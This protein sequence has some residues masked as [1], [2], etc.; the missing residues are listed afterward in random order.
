M[1]R[2][3]DDLRSIGVISGLPNN[4][5][6]I[7]FVAVPEAS[8]YVAKLLTCMAEAFLRLIDLIEEDDQ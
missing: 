1:A 3:C 2:R 6:Y 7:G 4:A 8:V 5:T